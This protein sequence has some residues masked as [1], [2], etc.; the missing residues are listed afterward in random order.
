MKMF[1]N[2]KGKTDC[3]AIFSCHGLHVA[4]SHLVPASFGLSRRPDPVPLLFHIEF[5]W[6]PEHKLR[7]D[8]QTWRKEK[9]KRANLKTTTYA[10]QIILLEVHRA[11]LDEE[12]ELDPNE[13]ITGDGMLR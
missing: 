7:E 9:Q 2:K 3:R 8:R 12:L 10:L 4:S 6:K 13:D 1:W 11:D 5:E